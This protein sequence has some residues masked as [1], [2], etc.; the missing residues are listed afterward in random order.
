ME[1]KKFSWVEGKI[2]WMC[3]SCVRQKTADWIESFHLCFCEEYLGRGA[4]GWNKK[5]KRQCTR[6]LDRSHVDKVFFFFSSFLE[7]IHFAGESRIL[8]LVFNVF[9]FTIPSIWRRLEQYLKW[10]CLYGFDLQRIIFFRFV[11]YSNFMTTF[12]RLLLLWIRS[13]LDK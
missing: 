12:S 6:E 10:K 7:K 3:G 1:K 9:C 11:V 13:E 8:W 2:L 4:H 5:T